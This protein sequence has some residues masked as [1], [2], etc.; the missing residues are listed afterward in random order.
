ME[1]NNQSYMTSMTAAKNAKKKKI[2]S[3]IVAIVV[4]AVAAVVVYS[5]MTRNNKYAGKYYEIV[6]SF[7]KG[8]WRYTGNYV[9]L[10]KN[11]D[12]VEE[13][14]LSSYTCKS[15][16]KITVTQSVFGAT[17]RINGTIKKGVLTL[18]G[19]WWDSSSVHYYVRLDSP[20]ENYGP[21]DEIPNGD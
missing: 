5:V 18:N 14:L 3:L 15:G 2:I 13:G 17:V 12:Y 6:D 21:F 16:G 4:I 19:S 20:P 10:S 9:E 8:E 7:N 11:G 1:E